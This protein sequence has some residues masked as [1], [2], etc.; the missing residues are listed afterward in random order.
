MYQNDVLKE[1]AK[2]MALDYNFVTDLTSLVVRIDDGARNSQKNIFKTGG[3]SNGSDPGMNSPIETNLNLSSL[4]QSEE[5]SEE[6]GPCKITLYSEDNYQG[7]GQT[8]CFSV[9]DLSVWEFEEKLES[10]E[11]E[12]TCDWRIFKGETLSHSL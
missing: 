6:C 11:V 5:N 7:E 3:S 4:I 10:V 1:R 12:G 2:N 9:P 8:I